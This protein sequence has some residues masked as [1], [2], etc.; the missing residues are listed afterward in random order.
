MIV[1]EFI[2]FPTISKISVHNYPLFDYG[3]GN[4]W[5]TTF[6][7]GLNL[8]LGANS[9]GKTTTINMVVY[10][11]VGNF[12][13]ADNTEVNSSFFQE[14]LLPF[15]RN[16]QEQIIEVEFMIGFSIINIRRNI[17]RNSI[18]RLIVIENGQEKLIAI[19]KYE[20]Y[21]K[22]VTRIS[23]ISDLAFVLSF[24][25][26]REEEGNYLLWQKDEQSK[27]FSILLNQAGFHKEL[28]SLQ[29][30]FEKADNVYKVAEDKYKLAI[31]R[32]NYFKN[33]QKEQ[34]TK[35]NT[36][37]NIEIFENQL[38]VKNKELSKSELNLKVKRLEIKEF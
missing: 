32:L 12:R 11:I 28:T 37:S 38:K 20:E 22:S 10:A 8:F 27:I 9:I 34:L 4:S 17:G 7:N 23:D 15:E 29:N 33:K 36:E 26:I 25:M 21:I 1:N 35:Y 14:R 18:D 24:L 31:E 19:S 2:L 13:N 6:E 5:T 30:E 16:I 3:K